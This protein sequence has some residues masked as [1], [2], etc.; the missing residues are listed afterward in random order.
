MREEH[1]GT[2]CSCCATGEIKDLL[3][4]AVTGL[5][6]YCGVS[7][8]AQVVGLSFAYNKIVFTS[9][10]VLDWLHLV[11]ITQQS[12]AGTTHNLRQ[13][14]RSHNKGTRLL[15]VILASYWLIGFGTSN[16]KPV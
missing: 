16:R 6:Y 8:P 7:S 9:P 2:L 14:Y 12:W 3:G 15:A 13:M 5:A 11:N 4:L 1:A 10:V